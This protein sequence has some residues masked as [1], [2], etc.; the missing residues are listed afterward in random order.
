MLIFD[1]FLYGRETKGYFK[2]A[3]QTSPITIE[4]LIY[5]FEGKVRNPYKIQDPSNN[6]NFNYFII[7]NQDL[8]P[9]ENGRNHRFNSS[10]FNDLFQNSEWFGMFSSNS[11]SRIVIPNQSVITFNPHSKEYGLE[12]DRGQ[13]L[14][15]LNPNNYYNELILT[16][17]TSSTQ[18]IELAQ[19]Y[20]LKK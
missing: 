2:P 10:R 4:D 7:S 17:K 16:S 15:S 1:K 9:L 6:R 14:R 11:T 8:I 12:L 19:K 3:E 13:I 18:V 20:Y 5:I